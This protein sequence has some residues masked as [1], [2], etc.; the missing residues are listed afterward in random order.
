VL[1]D[2]NKI[3][4]PVNYPS[5]P[6]SELPAF[7]AALRHREG[8][9]A[10]ALEFLILCASRTG[11]VLGAQWSEIDLAN[12]VWTVPPGR[13]K[14]GVQHRVTLA[15]R[16]VDLLR[17]LPR[18]S[19]NDFVFIGARSG[20]L[21][22][23]AMMRLLHAMGHGNISVHGFRGTFR[24]WAAEQTNFAREVAEMALAHKIS[25]KV[26][27]TYQRGEL[28][29]KRYLLAEAWNKFASSPPSVKQKDDKVVP[30]HA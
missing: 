1:P 28:L 3:A 24:T 9:A 14:A 13:M 22:A 23:V 15:R 30:P 25:D 19:G 29:R 12:K 10:R 21:S 2:R 17:S 8:T 5:L 7:M 18:E 4:K 11:E 27:A 16:A 20:G 26:E 6:Y